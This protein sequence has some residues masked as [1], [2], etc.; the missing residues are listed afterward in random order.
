MKRQA[1]KNHLAFYAGYNAVDWLR[2][3]D[4]TGK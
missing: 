1:K 3:A 2:D 4:K